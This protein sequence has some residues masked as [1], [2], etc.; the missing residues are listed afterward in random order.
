MTT[1]TPLI[2]A[3]VLVVDEAEAIIE[4]E[5]LRLT[6]DADQC[7]HTVCKLHAE[8]PAA[9]PRPPRRRPTT[10]ARRPPSPSR[11]R[12]LTSGPRP[13]SAA[14]TVRPTQRS[15]PRPH[16]DQRADHVLE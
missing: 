11:P 14:P 3:A 16:H 5:W 6:R 1:D 9:R 8:Q 4:A 12:R 10:V 15:P 7:E 13:R 2:A